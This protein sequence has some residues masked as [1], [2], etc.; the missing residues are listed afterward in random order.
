MEDTTR[1]LLKIILLMVLLGFFFAL[2]V[3]VA[4]P[5][6]FNLIGAIN[7]ALYNIPASIQG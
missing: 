4:Q 3:S 1:W 7:Q 2:I 6:S 5:A